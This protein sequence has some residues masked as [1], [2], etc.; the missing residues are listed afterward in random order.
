MTEYNLDYFY[1]F[2]NKKSYMRRTTAL[3][4]A[5]VSSDL[6]TVEILFKAGA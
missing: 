5:V 3:S 6:K 1:D 2:N 4:A